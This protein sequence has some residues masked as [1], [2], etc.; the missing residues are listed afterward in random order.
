[1]IHKYTTMR[2]KGVLV[3]YE[4]YGTLSFI[5]IHAKL[6]FKIPIMAFKFYETL[7]HIITWDLE[8]RGIEYKKYETLVTMEL[9]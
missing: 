4:K 7:W 2:L 6:V 5:Q 1:M 8:G 3:I 9:I